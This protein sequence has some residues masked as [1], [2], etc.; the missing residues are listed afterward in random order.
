MSAGW[1]R[2]RFYYEMRAYSDAMSTIKRIIDVAR[3]AGNF[4]ELVRLLALQAVIL[5]NAGSASAVSAALREAIQLGAMQGSIRKWL[6]AGPRIIPL[7]ERERQSRGYSSQQMA[8]VLAVQDA[9]RMVLRAEGAPTESSSLFALSDR[10]LEVLQLIEAG[11]SNQQIADDLVI[12]LHTVK[13]HSSNIYSK[14]GVGSRTQA[15]VRARA[16]GL[17]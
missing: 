10:E 3:R 13:K 14:L 6:D 9:C 11:Y 1:M 15:V 16:I 12:T 17:L 8:Y 7:L 2:A 5:D 4:G